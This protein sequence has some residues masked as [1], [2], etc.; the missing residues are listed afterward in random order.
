MINKIVGT[1]CS[2]NHLAYAKTMGESFIKFNPDY[3]V[4]ICLVD[5]IEGRFNP[6]DFAPFAIIEVDH[7]AIPQFEKMSTQYSIIEL[8]CGIK[9][10]LC[11]YILKTYNPDI[12]LYVDSDILFFNSIGIAEHL[13]SNSDIL[14]TPHI[15]TPINDD[16]NPKERDF[17]R[18]G[19]YNA[20][21]IGLKNC[22]NVHNFL[23][24]WAERLVDQC[25]VNFTEG[26]CFDQNWLNLVPL[27]FNSVNIV[28]HKGFNVAYWN[29]HE[30]IM[31][32]TEDTY[33]IN[34]VDPL[35]F[36]HISGYKFSNPESL[37]IHQNRIKL[38]KFPVLSELL[39]N[40]KKQVEENGYNQFIN[41]KC[42]YAKPKK[43]SMGIMSTINK[44]IG[45]WG[46]K[47]TK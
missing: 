16:L 44:V 36:L 24:W 19:I 9:P 21:F 7:L 18:S 45:I 23:S 41:L 35:I 29:L 3:S 1:V 20:G 15:L 39:G 47:L 38:N 30:R 43:K 27:F 13:L 6:E 31:N 8:N 17:L 2:A 40:Y 25:Y 11:Q 22:E 46:L 26:M 5:K 14:I 33:F 42:Y 12:L 32:K 34:Q 4:I 10:Y 37:S 28:T